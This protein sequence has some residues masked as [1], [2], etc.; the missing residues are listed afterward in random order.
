MGGGGGEL[1]KSQINPNIHK[2]HLH[3]ILCFMF[4]PHILLLFS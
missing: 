2:R 3:V 4:L 1:W